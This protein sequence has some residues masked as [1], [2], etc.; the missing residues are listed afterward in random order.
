MRL[1]NSLISAAF[2]GLL[3]TGAELTAQSEPHPE[4]T[5][6]LGHLE[7]GKKAME[8][9]DVKTAISEFTVASKLVPDSAEYRYE[10]AM[11]HLAA[12]DM[13]AT[14]RSLR[15]AARL[16]PNEP[17]IAGAFGRYWSIFDG[18]GLFNVGTPIEK[19]VSVLGPADQDLPI[20][21]RQR[22]VFSF[23]GVDCVDGKVDEILDLRGMQSYHVNP[24]EQVKISL[25]G[26]DWQKNYAINNRMVNTIEY[27]LPGEQVQNFTEMM[28][29][30]RFH[31]PPARQNQRPKDVVEHMMK[32]L[33]ESNPD[34]KYRIIEE[35]EQSALYEWT[36]GGSENS[37]AQ[38][39]VAKILFRKLDMHRI[40]YV[41]KKKMD[42]AARKKWVEILRGAKLGP[43]AAPTPSKKQASASS[44]STKESRLLAWRLGSKLSGAAVMHSQGADASKTQ[45]TFKLAEQAAASLGVS[46]P[47][48][49]ELVGDKTKDTVRA[50]EYLL[51]TAGRQLHGQLV[52]KYG[53]SHAALLEVA[54]KSNLLTMIY[55]PGDSTSLAAA[56][57]IQDR[58]PHAELPEVVWK[59]LTNGIEKEMDRRSVVLMVL[60]MHT[61][62]ENILKK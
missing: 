7:A 11:A 28:S 33:A 6:A 42:E 18:K 17:K 36:T 8:A 35:D 13:P 5:A 23:Y 19:I 14:W 37:A 2:L 45:A 52:A 9:K 61:D 24:T 3:V 32:T 40:A 46:V 41:N 50:I 25:D 20:Q 60:K 47:L 1:A 30:Q 62:V 43:Y 22:Y 49:P 56:K 4:E 39:E 12:E 53:R 44:L 58:G 26:R 57:A 27:T 55:A 51:A 10:L 38:Y 54:I 29:L 21:H 15:V 34:R 31:R 16:A 59:S 48:L